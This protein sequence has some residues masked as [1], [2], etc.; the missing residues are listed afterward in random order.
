MQFRVSSVVDN[1]HS[2]KAKNAEAARIP[3]IS[4]NRRAVEQT[5][6]STEFSF[7]EKLKEHQNLGK[8]F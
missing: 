3:V 4:L 8:L 2:V 5:I 7:R 6:R 1:L